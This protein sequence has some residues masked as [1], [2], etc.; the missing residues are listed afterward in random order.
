M[1]RHHVSTLANA[2]L[3]DDRLVRAAKNLDDLAIGAAILFDASDAHH[4]AI[5][6]HTRLR[7]FARDVNVA[8]QAFDGV[9]GNQKPVAV[10]MHVQTPDRIFTAEARDYKTA[11]ANFDELAFFYQPV[12]S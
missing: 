7:R 8:A 11:G 10:A 12:E 5:A 6:M 1:G 2:K 9:I 4:Y 3:S